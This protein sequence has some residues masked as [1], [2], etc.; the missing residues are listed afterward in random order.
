MAGRGKARTVEVILKLPLHSGGKPQRE[1]PDDLNL[2]TTPLRVPVLVV[3]AL[4]LCMLLAVVRG[5]AVKITMLLLLLCARVLA[6]RM[7]RLLLPTLNLRLLLRVFGI[8]A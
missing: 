5:L 1:R 7:M 8:G 6:C 3:M 4:G 2:A